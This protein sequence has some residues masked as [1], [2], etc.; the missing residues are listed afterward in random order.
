MYVIR[1]LKNVPAQYRG[2]AVTIGNFDGVHLGHQ[3]L[4]EN[5]RAIAN[6]R[7]VPAVGLTFEPHPIRVLRPEKAPQRITCVRGKIRFMEENGADAVLIMRFTHALAAHSPEEFVRVVLAEGLGAVEVLVGYNFRFGAKGAGDLEMLRDLGEKYGF[8]V[9]VQPPFEKSGQP[10]SS[11][12]VRGAIGLPD[13]ELAEELLGR[14]FEVESRVGSGMK[15]GRALGFPTANLPI[16]QR[17]HPP[18]GVYI[19]EGLVDGYW[20]PAVANLG[21][22][23]TFGDEGL[24]LE[25]HMLAPCGDLYRKVLR[26]RFLRRIREEIKFAGPEELVARINLDIDEAKA[27]F[28]AHGIEV[29]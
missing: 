3:A 7:D 1:G 21:T 2:A 14:S 24:H 18:T 13:F 19:V 29:G 16:C 20:L 6:Q 28:A 10:V 26:V 23:P 11:T 17:V 27:F 9:T 4:F 12:R 22:N 5:L 8:G 25:V 15:R